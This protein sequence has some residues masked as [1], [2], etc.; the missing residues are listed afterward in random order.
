MVRMQR[1]QATAAALLAAAA[2]GADLILLVKPQFEATRAEVDA[3]KGVIRDPEIHARVLAEV[4]GTLEGLGA[5]IMGSM[6]SP[7]RGADGNVEF[8]LHVVAPG[9]PA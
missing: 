4:S 3:G 5:A 9:G 8:L 7:L 2:P 6:H 1:R